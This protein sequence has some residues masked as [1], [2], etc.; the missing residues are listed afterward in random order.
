VPDRD[1]LFTV[2]LSNHQSLSGMLPPL[3]ASVVSSL[4]FAGQ[5]G[6]DL[7][8]QIREAAA[9]GAA[10]GQNACGLHFRTEGGALQIE[11]ASGDYVWRAT[12]Q[13]P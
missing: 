8:D 1:F 3:I 5:P 7:I 9:R 12:H 2:E 6:A 4:G 11:V 13:L 10:A